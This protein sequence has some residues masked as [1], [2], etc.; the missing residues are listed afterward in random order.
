VTPKTTELTQPSANPR[1]QLGQVVATPA[2]LDLL[3]RAGVDARSVL[4]R[5]W[6]CD[7]NDLCKEDR[8]LNEEAVV[9]GSR[10]FS[11]YLID[12]AGERVWVIT[13]AADDFGVRRVTIILL[14]EDY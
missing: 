12:A 4:A 14:P 10:I 8:L 6:N 5:H 13:D 7:W 3:Q 2:A 11:S 1:F 9:D